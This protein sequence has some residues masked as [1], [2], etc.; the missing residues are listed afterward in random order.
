MAKHNPL[1]CPPPIK[2]TV[3][4]GLSYH[5]ARMCERSRVLTSKVTERY[6]WAD[7][8]LAWKTKQPTQQPEQPQ[9]PDEQNGDWKEAEKP[10]AESESHQDGDNTAGDNDDNNHDDYDVFDHDKITLPADKIWKP[11]LVLI[12]EVQPV[13][14]DSVNVIILANGSVF[15]IVQAIYKTLCI[16]I[17]NTDNSFSCNYKFGP[18]VHDLNMTM[19]MFHGGMDLAFYYD[20]CKPYVIEKYRAMVKTNRFSEGYTYNTF[21]IEQSIKKQCSGS[22]DEDDDYNGC[23]CGC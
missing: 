21:E 1:V 19:E 22:A 15:W 13:H 17:K 16:P 8:T 7:E 4:F 18:W 10:Y 5:C 20:E 14:R 23:E 12:N 11:Q 6:H 9:Q 2:M 3:Q